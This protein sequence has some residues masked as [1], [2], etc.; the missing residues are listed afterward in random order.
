VTQ[1]REAQVIAQDEDTDSGRHK[2]QADPETPIMMRTP[3]IRTIVTLQAHPVRLF[4]VVV[5]LP[6][7]AH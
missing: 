5:S 1:K 4:V 3:P 7:L 6:I 2:N